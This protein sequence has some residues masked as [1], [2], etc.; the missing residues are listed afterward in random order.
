MADIRKRLF[1][2]RLRAEPTAYIRLVRSGRVIREGAGLAFWF[3]PLT[4]A[5]S[6]V[7]IEERELPLVFH[8]RTKDFQDVVVQASA[9]FRVAEPRL[10][11]ER[12][13]FS[14]DPDT[15]VWH[16]TPLEQIAGVLTELAQQ[17]AFDVLSEKALTD[18]LIGGLPSVRG[19]VATGLG[20]DERLIEIGLEV[21]GVRVVA[22]RPESDLER[23]LQMPIR[24]QLQQDADKATYGRRA[25]AV[26]RERA[27][28]ENE[29]QSQIELAI[30]EEQLVAQRGANTRR[31][32][33]ENAAAEKILA[34][35]SA[36]R[37]EVIAKA[38]AAA[39]R[40]MGEANA[41]AEAEHLKAYREISE[42]TLLGLALKELAANLPSIDTLV[43]SPDVVTTALARLGIASN[44][45]EVA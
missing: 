25:I 12:I 26:E 39:A 13:D 7:P 36:G 3:R 32:A 30:R 20:T 29:L 14:I 1:L 23:A 43:L 8:G 34:E 44:G 21:V 2:R 17:Y 19:A 41:F 38:D 45:G 22:L 15:G 18:L 31:E 16:S 42:A 11:A 24:E 37:T 5:V 10:A 28:S 9:T 6:E 35:A 4:V 40:V 33:E 27:I